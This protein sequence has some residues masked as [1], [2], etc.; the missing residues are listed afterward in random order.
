MPEVFSAIGIVSAHTDAVPLS[1]SGFEFRD[2]AITFV[3]SANALPTD[4]TVWSLHSSGLS[5][6]VLAKVY[7]VTPVCRYFQLA[8]Y[9]ENYSIEDITTAIQ[10]GWK[11]AK[12]E[13]M[14]QLSFHKETSL[15]IAVGPEASVNQ[16]PAVLNELQR[17]RGPAVERI[18]K[19]QKELDE[20]AT[21]QGPEWDR[22]RAEIQQ[23]IGEIAQRQ[24]ANELIDRGGGP[25]P[26]IINRSGN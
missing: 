6:K 12:V 3:N 10:T 7:G 25:R 15:L 1:P 23:K 16:I 14:P 20:I 22:K 21:K 18:V 5:T 4:E 13:P 26:R 24:L 17:D 19:L 11:M 2:V 8:S 9:L